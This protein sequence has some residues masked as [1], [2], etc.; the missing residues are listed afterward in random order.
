M[1]ALFPL[2]PKS[3][4]NT[5]KTFSQTP[6]KILILLHNTYFAAAN[7]HY[8]LSLDTVIDVFGGFF[9]LVVLRLPS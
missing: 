6:Y 2:I 5:L 8:V 1:P 9:H 4:F 7:L 3:L